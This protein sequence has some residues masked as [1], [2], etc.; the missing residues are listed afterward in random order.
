[1]TPQPRPP[2]RPRLTMKPTALRLASVNSDSEEDGQDRDIDAA[3]AAAFASFLPEPESGTTRGEGRQDSV[4]GSG[5]APL[6][7]GA[8]GALNALPAGPLPVQTIKIVSKQEALETPPDT[9]DEFRAWFHQVMDY[10]CPNM[11]PKKRG[12]I[13]RFAMSLPEDGSHT[14]INK[15]ELVHTLVQTPSGLMPFRFHPAYRSSAHRALLLGTSASSS[16]SPSTTQTPP[17]RRNSNKLKQQAR[18]WR[19]KQNKH[20]AEK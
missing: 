2:H 14:V 12:E 9:D 15:D 8:V 1:M 6:P 7:L 16:S 13:L 3:V 20:N 18:S 11:S 10:E 4:R 19:R 5:G 17:S